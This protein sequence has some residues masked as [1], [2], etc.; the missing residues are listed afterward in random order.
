MAAV[1]AVIDGRKK[2]SAGSSDERIQADLLRLF[3]AHWRAALIALGVVTAAVFVVGKPYASTS[4]W[5]IWAVTIGANTLWQASICRLMEL[6][7][8]PLEAVERWLPWLLVNLGINGALWGLFPILVAGSTTTVLTS[9][10]LFDAMLL[11][12]VATSPGTRTM[13]WIV[14]PPMGALGA[15]AILLHGAPSLFALG[16]VAL[17]GVISAF[18]LQLN[19]ALTN[20]LRARY[21]AEGLAAQLRQQQDRLVESEHQRTLL[22]ERERLTRDMHD[23]LGSALL[24]SLVAVERGEVRPVELGTLLRE[25]VD[26][27]RSVI[28]SLEPDGNDL[29]AVLASS[30]ERLQRNVDA[31]GLRFEW[32]MGD[33]PPLAWMGPSQS[34]HVLRIV[35]EALSNAVRHA[36]AA[37][38]RFEARALGSEIEIS[39]AD[40][41]SGFDTAAIHA[42]RGLRSLTSRANLLGGHV[43][44]ESKDGGGTCIQ[45][46]IPVLQ[47]QPASNA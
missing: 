18:G 4:M 16:Y 12:C 26:D 31:A 19:S 35:Q 25:C 6:A 22:I 40:D 13:N 8:T 2:A 29:V 42:G 46:R 37:S 47:P 15:V 7:A 20:T 21:D 9:A 44:I 38:V 24:A 5:T 1:T 10:C 41:G 33:L 45:L 34:L 43:R 39:V 11:Y 3:L 27:L 32:V 14:A 28:S 30:R 17:A 36:D 23:G